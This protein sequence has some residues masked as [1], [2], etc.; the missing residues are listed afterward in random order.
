MEETL[1]LVDDND[2]PIGTASREEC[3]KGK[4]KRHR[5]F[6]VFLFDSKGRILLQFRNKNKLGGNRWD[7][8]ATSHVRK[9]ETYDSAA[10]RCMKHEIGISAPLKK[11]GAFVYT[12]SYGDYSENEYCVVLIGKFSGKVTPNKEEIDEIKYT[13]LGELKKDVEKKPNFY[14]KWLR[15]SFP[16]LY[17]FIEKSGYPAG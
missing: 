1:I 5:A 9:G 2:N 11:I 7:I 16:I 13:A 10:E 4:G 15:G 3:H 14:T 12:E 8:T 6:V 17:N